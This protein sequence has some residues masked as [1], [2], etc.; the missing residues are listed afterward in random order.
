MRAGRARCQTVI[1]TREAASVALT[2]TAGY[3]STT[4]SSLVRRAISRTS[5]CSTAASRAA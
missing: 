1:A 4:G 3:V 5:S 2:I